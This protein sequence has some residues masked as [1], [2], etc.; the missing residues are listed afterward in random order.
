VHQVHIG[1]C[2]DQGV[3]DSLAKDGCEPSDTGWEWTLD[4]LQTT[5]PTIQPLLHHAFETG[6]LTDCG[7]CGLVKTDDPANHRDPCV[8]SS[9]GVGL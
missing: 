5:E 6:F 2:G 3:L 1:V 7:A 9:S 8:S 4:P